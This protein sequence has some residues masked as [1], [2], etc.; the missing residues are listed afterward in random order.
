MYDDIIKIVMVLPIQIFCRTNVKSVI[1]SD[2]E[3]IVE[4]NYQI[5]RKKSKEEVMRCTVKSP[6]QQ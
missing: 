6:A 1:L 2:L 5:M 4:I 3:E